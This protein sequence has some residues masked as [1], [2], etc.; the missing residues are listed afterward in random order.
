MIPDYRSR[1]PLCGGKECAV[2]HGLYFRKVVGRD[3]ELWERFPVPRFLCRRRGPG[4]P[5][6]VTFS[7]LPP[8]TDRPVVSDTD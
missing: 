5:T 1:C 6:A 7:V 8:D 4:K 3:G 2:R